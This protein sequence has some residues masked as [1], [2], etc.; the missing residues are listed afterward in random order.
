[1]TKKLEAFCNF[2]ALH[3]QKMKMYLPKIIKNIEPIT[4]H[5]CYEDD[6]YKKPAIYF[7]V[8][9]VNQDTDTTGHILSSIALY[10]ILVLEYKNFIGNSLQQQ[11]EEQMEKY[12][13][14]QYISL[15]MQTLFDA[16]CSHYLLSPTLESPLWIIQNYLDIKKTLTKMNPFIIK[17]IENYLTHGARPVASN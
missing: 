12:G 5:E 2:H 17:Q 6:H 15:D 9:F 11:V 3:Q 10:N 1:M 4:K 8:D 13:K 14:C 16:Y 7:D